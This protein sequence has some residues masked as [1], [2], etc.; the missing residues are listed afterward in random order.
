M[1]KTVHVPDEPRFV[2][3]L[4]LAVDPADALSFL[5]EVG[6]LKDCDLGIVRRVREALEPAYEAASERKDWD[7]VHATSILSN[8]LAQP[9]GAAFLAYRVAHPQLAGQS[10]DLAEALAVAGCAYEYHR[11]P[12]EVAR[13]PDSFSLGA[14]R[15]YVWRL[16]FAI[17]G[18][19]LPK[20][21]QPPV[22]DGDLVCSCSEPGSPKA[23]AGDHAAWCQAH[24][25]EGSP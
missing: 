10:N 4:A 6:A 25:D 2:R 8:A 15:G 14:W 24:R 13:E 19:A 16:L 5:F 22:G 7:L 3:A 11:R 1:N 21:G 23:L 12:W 18:K 17:P 9:D 20:P